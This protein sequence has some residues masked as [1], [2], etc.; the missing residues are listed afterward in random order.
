MIM[1]PQ[2]PDRA[3]KAGRWLD[4]YDY[5]SYSKR[6]RARRMNPHVHPFPGKSA[7][8]KGLN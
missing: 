6:S 8:S 4:E 5:C 3:M 7:D 1:G 2:T